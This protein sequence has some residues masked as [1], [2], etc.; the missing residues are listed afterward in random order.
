MQTADTIILP[1]SPE[2]ATYRTDVHGWVSRNGFFY[3]DNQDSE[4]LARLDGATHR[5]CEQCGAVIPLRGYVVCPP[6]RHA[7]QRERYAQRERREWDGQASLYSE[8][9][10]VYFRDED[11]IIEHLLDHGGTVDD[12]MLLI[13]EPER[14]YPLD[15]QEIY[16]SILPEDGDLPDEIVAAFDALNEAIEKCTA[17][18]SWYPGEY[19]AVV[20]EI[21]LADDDDDEGEIDLGDEAEVAS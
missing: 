6:C 10:S 7:N 17:V 20:G 5:E 11:D 8:T 12:L 14:A 19:A 15:P 21:D 3:G 2:A 1:S 18:I 16:E 4:R 9:A 13:C